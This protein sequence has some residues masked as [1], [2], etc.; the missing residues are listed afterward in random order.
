MSPP[1]MLTKDTTLAEA[2][3][4][5]F[6]RRFAAFWRSAVAGLLSLNLQEMKAIQSYFDRQGRNPTD[7]ELETIAQ[8]WSEHCKHKTFSGVTR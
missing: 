7:I 2:G 3:P 5:P 6:G 4:D 8:T 1:F